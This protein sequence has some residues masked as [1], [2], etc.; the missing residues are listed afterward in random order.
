MSRGPRAPSPEE[1]RLWRSVTRKVSPIGRSA[2]EAEPGGKERAAP[3]PSEG[4]KPSTPIRAP[5]PKRGPETPRP[6]DLDRRTAAKVARGRIAIDARVDLHGLTQQAAH[7]RLAAFLHDAQADGASLVLV[8]TGKGLASRREE[9]D[10]RDR[11]VLR[12]MVPEWLRSASL[13]PYVVGFGEAGRHHG[14]GG[15]LYVRIRRRKR[16]NRG[17]TK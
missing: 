10:D 15:A 3:A 8:I 7:R 17:P 9:P 6:A 11:G 5:V 16:L 1:L 12:R 2:Q 13:R 4:T 14:G